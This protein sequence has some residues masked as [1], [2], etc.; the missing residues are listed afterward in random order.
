[1]NNE[2]KTSNDDADIISTATKCANCGK[3][4][5]SS[6]DLKACTACKI[7]KYCNRECQIAH[8]PQHKKLCRKRAAELYNE[9]LFNETPPREECPICMLSLLHES[10]TASFFSCC[11]K[12]ICNGCIYTMRETGGKNM[13]LCPFCKT[14]PAISEEEE[15]GRVKK[16]S[17]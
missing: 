13:E 1:M 3:G 17:K 12:R 14:P 16:L 5:E 7:V 15:V 6:S 9:K 2:K 11:G 4:E 10:E 8:R